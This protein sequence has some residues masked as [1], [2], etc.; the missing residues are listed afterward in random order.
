MGKIF[1]VLSRQR[2]G[3]ALALFHSLSNPSFNN[4]KEIIMFTIG[5]TVKRSPK[6]WANDK[7]KYT[8]LSYNKGVYMVQRHGKT[9][10]DFTGKMEAHQPMPYQ[11]KELVAI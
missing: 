11:A 3:E 4:L 5:Q 10:N 7:A 8:V 1:P 6:W 2:K 9:K